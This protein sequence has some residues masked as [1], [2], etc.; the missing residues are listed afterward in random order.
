MK[1]T[2]IVVFWRQLTSVN[3][4]SRVILWQ[5]SMTLTIDDHD[6][7]W[8]LL[9]ISDD[10]QNFQKEKKVI[11]ENWRYRQYCL[12]SI[13][14]NQFLLTLI[15]RQLMSIDVKRCQLTS[16]DVNWCQ[17]MSKDVNWRQNMSKDVNWRQKMSIDIKRCLLTSKDVF[18][19]NKTDLEFKFDLRWPWYWLVFD[20]EFGKC[21]PCKSNPYFK[22]TF[23]QSNV[24]SEVLKVVDLLWS[25]GFQ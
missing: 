6:V 22:I 2:S 7:F 20:N 5:R 3:V 17:N 16:I 18:W 13:D 19:I 23:C 4:T 9:K 8:Q 1:L 12:A 25:V 24:G 15:I 14:V 21:C 10:F 11:D